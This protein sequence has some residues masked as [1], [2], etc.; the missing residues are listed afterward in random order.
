MGP[1]PE[2]IHA[3]VE[4][5]RRNPRFGCLRIS[6]QINKAFGLD[7]DKDMVRRVLAKHYHPTPD[8]DGPSWLTCSDTRKTA[9]GA[10]TCFGANPFY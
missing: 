10:L 3:F 4:Q 2:L 6:Q 1:S 9:F 8:D 5:K 7:I